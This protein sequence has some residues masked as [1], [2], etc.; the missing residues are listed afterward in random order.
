M[1][2]IEDYKTSKNKKVTYQE[3]TKKPSPEKKK[4]QIEILAKEVTNK[5]RT[6]KEFQS[7]KN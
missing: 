5:F 7:L 6:T 1:G 4:S 3:E 2:L